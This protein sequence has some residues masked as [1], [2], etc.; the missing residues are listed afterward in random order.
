MAVIGKIRKQSG[1]LMILIGGAMVA[2]ILGDLLGSG[3]SLLG[4]GTPNEVGEINGTKISYA[5]FENQVEQF[6]ISRYGGRSVDEQ[7]RQQV[8]NQVWNQII[9]EEILHPQYKDLGLIVSNEEVI[10]NI[11]NNPNNG[12]LRSYFSN[13]QTGQI[14][15]RFANPD[16]SLNSKAVFN[17]LDQVLNQGDPSDQNVR[18]AKN[19]WT[20]LESGIKQ[21]LLDN[22]YATLINKGLYVTNLE[23]QDDATDNAN[24]VNFSY[25]AK[26]YSTIKDAEVSYTDADLK[27]YYNEHKNEA[28]FE[29]NEAVRAAD[30][31]VFE[32]L[33]SAE[34]KKNLEKELADLRT[35]FETSQDDTL[36]INENS[37]TPMNLKWASEGTF[38]TNVDSNIMIAEVGTVIGPFL[39]G[40]K[41]EL[42]K[43]KDR[44]ISSDSVKARHILL[45]ADTNDINITMEKADSLKKVIKKK[46]NF[47]ELATEFS[48]D[49]GSKVNGGDL[50]WF[51]EGR[52]VPE[53]ND[54]CFN[55]E[56]GD[57]VVIKTQFGV[58]LIEIQEKTAPKEKTLVAVVDNKIEPSNATFQ[59]AY[60][61][62]SSFSINN[63]SAEKFAEAG[64]EFG[65]IPAPSL[66]KNDPTMMGFENSR[67]L[68]K[69][70]FESKVGDVSEPFDLQDKYVVVLTKENREKGVLPFEVAKTQIEQA[71]I[72][73][74]KA[75]KIMAEM[76]GQTD[77][78]SLAAKVG[79]SVQNANDV[80][81]ASFS[82]QGIGVEP[83]L[84]GI[85]FTL[86]QGNTSVPIK[87]K[88]GVYVI[89]IDNESKA[90]ASSLSMNK[91]QIESNYK[92]RSRY[93]SFVALRD[94]TDIK[95]NRI[96]FY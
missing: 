34:D 30:Y 96:K 78:N 56:A 80:N 95:D 29:Q 43:I 10:Y 72:Q 70:V 33:A 22:K 20:Q 61:K 49:N 25:V 73:E 87:G 2:F 40:E 47:A 46:N 45:P 44:K 24:K 13:P 85:A 17:Y 38:P 74:K 50:G 76:K 18:D 77:L 91:A 66:R 58:H 26:L 9:R 28:L 39:N 90:D 16:G 83:E 31:V 35:S 54:A 59:K 1:L 94:K 69:W 67:S 53:F 5:Q 88:R 8:R 65:V 15:E 36:Y 27:K 62:A 82:V 55:G 42:V 32:V 71:V 6:L 37:D 41:F 63:N 51:T 19:A 52:M 14:V 12:T 81:F 57:L 23:A 93:E 4:G 92:G 75:E 64:K 60:N 11:K 7:T 68:V 86:G 48:I 3:S 79:S 21:E 84:Q 89:R